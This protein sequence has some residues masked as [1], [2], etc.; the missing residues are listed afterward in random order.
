MSGS[1]EQFLSFVNTYNPIKNINPKVMSIITK[2]LRLH[3]KNITSQEFQ[4]FCEANYNSG[5]DGILID[6]NDENNNPFISIYKEIKLNYL[7][8][9]E[10][11]LNVLENDIL[12]KTVKRVDQY[13]KEVNESTMKQLKN[14]IGNNL[15]KPDDPNTTKDITLFSVAN[16]NAIRLT[17]IEQNVRELLNEMYSTCQTKYLEAIDALYTSFVSKSTVDQ[18]SKF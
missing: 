9:A 1:I 2:K 12:N 7:E 10:K 15:N 8:Q 13:G 16:L 6:I 14:L 11:L 4:G 5:I 18:P 17:E 3:S